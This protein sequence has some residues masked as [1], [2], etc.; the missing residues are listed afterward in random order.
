MKTI[1]TLRNVVGTVGLLAGA[2]LMLK[3]LPD[4]QRY[5]RI[6]TM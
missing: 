3:A 5:I 4:L 2:Y 6:T 1:L